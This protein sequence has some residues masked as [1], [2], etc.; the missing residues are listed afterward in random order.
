M[1]LTI[2]VEDGWIKV[3]PKIWKEYLQAQRILTMTLKGLIDEDFVNYKKPAMV[4]EFPYCSFK[5]DKECGRQVCQNSDLALAPNIE[6]HEQAII[7]RYLANSIT[8]AIVM[9]GLEPFDSILSL[10]SLIH[11]LRYDYNCHDDIVI[12]TGYTK[13]ELQNMQLNILTKLKKYDNIIVKYGRF[14][15][16]CEPHY[17]EVLGVNLASPNQYAE[18]IS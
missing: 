17:D 7:K 10:M 6:I 3:T 2:G 18:R 9:Q 15:P 8:E 13:Q 12:Y 14:I 5:C 16:D 1:Y 4:L 11:L